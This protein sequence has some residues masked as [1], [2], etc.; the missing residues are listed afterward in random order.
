MISMLRGIIAL[1]VNFAITLQMVLSGFVVAIPFAFVSLFGNIRNPARHFIQ[2]WAY[3]IDELC[4]KKILGVKFTIEGN[5]TRAADDEII[6]CIANH[7]S[8]LLTP[9]FIRHITEKISGNLTAVSKREMGENPFIRLFLWI[10][11]TGILIDRSSNIQTGKALKAGVEKNVYPSCLILF[12]PDMHRPC[13]KLIEEDR[14][15]FSK[16]VPNVERWLKYTCMPRSGGLFTLLNELKGKN[17]GVVN[18][19]IACSVDDEY[20]YMAPSLVGSDV[21]IDIQE[22]KVPYESREKLNDWLN[23]E[24]EQKNCKIGVWKKINEFLG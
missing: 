17:V 8:S 3:F 10:T 1:V 23:K 20:L 12:Y 6:I 7:P 4:I 11:G 19:T 18:L 9:S 24:W 22:T 14:Q 5:V 15:K 21:Y 16:K 13:R 2:K